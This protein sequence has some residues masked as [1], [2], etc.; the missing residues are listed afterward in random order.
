MVVMAVMIFDVGTT[1][2]AV[3]AAIIVTAVIHSYCGCCGCF[4]AGVKAVV[5]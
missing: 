5:L 3:V 1:F 4:G 2:V